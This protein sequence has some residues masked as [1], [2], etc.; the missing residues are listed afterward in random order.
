MYYYN[1][2]KLIYHQIGI[3]KQ[4][5]HHFRLPNLSGPCCEAHYNNSEWDNYICERNRWKL[6]KIL[7]SSQDCPKRLHRSDHQLLLFFPALTHWYRS[8]G[9]AA[10]F[11]VKSASYFGGGKKCT[12]AT[13]GCSDWPKHKSEQRIQ[14]THTDSHSS[15]QVGIVAVIAH[16]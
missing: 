2:F 14:H 12:S 6:K 1:K 4:C 16:G 13:E 10:N 3:G 15:Q 11:P 7:T 5:Y 9:R 8:F